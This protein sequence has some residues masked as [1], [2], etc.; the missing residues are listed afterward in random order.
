[1]A[2]LP[3]SAICLPPR[4]CSCALVY[5]AAD[6]HCADRPCG[7]GGRHAF[8]CTCAAPERLLPPA[9]NYRFLPAFVARSFVHFFVAFGS[10]RRQIHVGRRFGLLR[11]LRRCGLLLPAGSRYAATRTAAADRTR[12]D[13][14]SDGHA[15]GCCCD[16]M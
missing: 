9:I 14:G 8:A 15:H 12:R 10:C 7:P 11:A 5:N 13:S 4:I 6:M 2:L 16:V 1:M 3:P